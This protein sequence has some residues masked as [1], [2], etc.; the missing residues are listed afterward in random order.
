MKEHYTNEKL[1]K[2]QPN[3]FDLVRHA[4][5]LSKQ[6]V[7]ADRRCRVATTVKNRPYQVL[8]E[9]AEGRDFLEVLPE[10]EPL[11]EIIVAEPIE[12]MGQ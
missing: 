11:Q 12:P 4:I 5:D 8:L 1:N 6:M 2:I 10:D 9:I 3:S 7:G